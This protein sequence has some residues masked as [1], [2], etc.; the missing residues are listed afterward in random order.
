HAI[1]ML[2]A[3][4]LADAVETRRG[5]RW[6]IDRQ[7]ADGSWYGRWGVNHVYGTGAAVPAL[8]AAGIEPSAECIRRAVGWLVACQNDD[9]GWGG[10]EFTGT[11]FPPDHYINSPLYRL[12]FPIM[13]LGRCLSIAA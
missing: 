13:A 1:E 4:G 12:V 2:V 11:G 3:L 6:L 8:I 5:V 9:G 10:A 7:E